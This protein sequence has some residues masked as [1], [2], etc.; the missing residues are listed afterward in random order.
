METIIVL[1][2]PV[3]TKT[4]ETFLSGMETQI[5][6]GLPPIR[7]RPLKPSLV[8]WKLITALSVSS[9]SGALETFLSGMET[10]FLK[11]IF[12]IFISP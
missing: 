2:P 6:S 12:F 5:Y 8:E 1:Q 3:P 10:I 7:R 9:K 11:I 4:L